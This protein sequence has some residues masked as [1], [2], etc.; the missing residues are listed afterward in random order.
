[1]STVCNK[2]DAARFAT[3]NLNLASGWV[4]LFGAGA[5]LSRYYKEKTKEKAR[6]A[7]AAG[8]VPE[9]ITWNQW[10]SWF[11]S[12]FN[13]ELQ[14]ENPDP[15]PNGSRPEDLELGIVH[16]DPENPLEPTPTEPVAS[17]SSQPNDPNT[18]SIPRKPVASGSTRPEEGSSN[19]DD[20]SSTPVDGSTKPANAEAI[21]DQSETKN[22]LSG[23]ENAG[24]ENDGSDNGPSGP[25]YAEPRP[26]M[27]R[28]NTD[29]SLLSQE[30]RPLLPTSNLR[31]RL[32]GNIPRKL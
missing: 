5:G 27:S 29:P 16:T 22:G 30:N 15:S 7:I 25:N 11:R 1:M 3:A 23:Y 18:F 28:A 32:I 19:P 14:A 20:G 8:E 17:G 31:R 24:P 26:D 6:A 4:S 12:M 2:I 10:R 21:Q 13:I 9:D